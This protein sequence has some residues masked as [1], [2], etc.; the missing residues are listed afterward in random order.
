MAQLD[1]KVFNDLVKK[2][3]NISPPARVIYWWKK[4]KRP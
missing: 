1:Q 3:K 2:L 4:Y